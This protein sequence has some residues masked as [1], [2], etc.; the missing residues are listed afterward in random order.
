MAVGEYQWLSSWFEDCDYEI[1]EI[2][3]KYG[4]PQEWNPDGKYDPERY[5][6]T[7]VWR[8]RGILRREI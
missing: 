5:V 8:D 3:K 7:H 4:L 1:I 6:E 2:I